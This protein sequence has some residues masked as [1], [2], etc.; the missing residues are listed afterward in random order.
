[1]NPTMPGRTPGAHPKSAGFSLLEL[2]A[3]LG[4]VAALAAI[5]FTVSRTA[6]THARVS[7]TKADLE[8]I[9]NILLEYRLREGFYPANLTNLIGSFGAS[10][11]L[12]SAGLPVDPWQREYIYTDVT[13][14]SYRL[15]STGPDAANDTDNIEEGQ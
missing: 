5:L 2:L 7:H 13:A 14:E 11:R 6:I 4:V 10:L 9:G 15:Y 1:M 12:G 8:R 3:V